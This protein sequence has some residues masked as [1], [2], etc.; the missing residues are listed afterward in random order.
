[1]TSRACQDADV[2]T[3]ERARASSLLVTADLP[4]TS[5]LAHARNSTPATSQTRLPARGNAVD[6]ATIADVRHSTVSS[7]QALALVTASFSPQSST[8]WPP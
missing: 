2:C 1:M 5:P 6:D 7:R 4:L 8:A 3:P